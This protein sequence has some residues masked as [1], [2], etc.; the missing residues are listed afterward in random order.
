MYDYNIVSG[1]DDP[2]VRTQIVHQLLLS[3]FE[4]A[5]VF[6]ARSV[7]ESFS[8]SLEFQFTHNSAAGCH[9]TRC[10][11]SKLHGSV[12]FIVHS[13]AKSSRRST[14]LFSLCLAASLLFSARQS[15]P[16]TQQP[17]SSSSSSSDKLS[18]DVPAKPA[19]RIAQPE[20]GGSAITLETSEPLFYVA[21]ALNVCGYDADLANSSPVRAKIREE[22]N[23]QVAA[24]AAARTSRDALCGYVREHTLTDGGLNLAQY[25]SLALYLSPPPELTPTVDQAELPPIPRRSSTSFP[26]SGPLPKTSASMPSGSSIVLSTKTLSPMSTVRS[27]K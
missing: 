17:S 15:H 21:V 9:C 16:P 2:A 19:P 24:S 6:G 23:A 3:V 22:I 13:P 10:S 26:S 8:P 4:P 12:E 7:A 1:S 18:N 25:I 20:A 14:A 11:P 27:P 5:S